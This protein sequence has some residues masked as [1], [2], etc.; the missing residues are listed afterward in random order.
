MSYEIESFKKYE[1]FFGSWYIKKKLG[2]GNFGAVFEI[3]REDFGTKYHAALKV[4]SIP[5]N[6]AE[7]ESIMND[8]LDEA[9]TEQYIKQ[10]V[11]KIIKEFELMAKLKGNSNIVSYEDHKVIKHEDD[12][13]WDILIRMELLTPMLK[14]VKT[15]V[16]T[17]RDVIGVGVDICRALELCEK[18]NIIHRDIKPENIFVSESGDFKLGDFG[19]A[20]Q[21]EESQTELTKIGT[22]T[23]MAPEVVKGHE[24][25]TS[26]DMYSLGVVLY[27]FLNHNRAPFMP[28]YPNPVD[29]SCKDMAFGERINGKKPFPTPTNAGSKELS[30]VIIK[31]C[32]YDPK[33]RFSSPSQM[34]RALENVLASES[35]EVLGVPAMSYGNAAEMPSCETPSVKEKTPSPV[36][37]PKIGESIE[38]E[39]E[40]K[41][42]I[43][44]SQNK[45][46]VKSGETIIL[47][48][49]TGGIV[50]LT[51]ASDSPLFVE[52]TKKD[53]SK[54]TDAS[55]S[56]SE[57]KL[58]PG[59]KLLVKN[60]SDKSVAF[61]GKF[62]AASA[63]EKE[64]QKKNG[65]KAKKKSKALPVI[66]VILVLILAA[67]AAVVLFGDKLGLFGEKQKAS[68]EKHEISQPADEIDDNS[69]FVESDNK[70]EK[71]KTS[72]EEEKAKTKFEIEGVPEDVLIDMDETVEISPEIIPS[73]EKHGDFVFESKDETVAKIDEIGRITP[74]SVGKTVVVI[75]CEN[76]KKEIN[77]NVVDSFDKIDEI[78][79]AIN[80]ASTEIANIESVTDKDISVFAE[81][82]SGMKAFVEDTGAIDLESL[83]YDDLVRI[84]DS[85]RVFNDDIEALKQE[86]SS[87][88]E[89]EKCPYCASTAHTKHPVCSYCGSL[90][91]TT[92]PKCPHCGS[93]DHT[94]HPRC[95]YCG[96]Y[97]HTSHP[98]CSYCGSLDHTTHP[99]CNVCGSLDHAE[100]PA[101]LPD[102]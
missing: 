35:D 18:H 39:P 40:E 30:D 73:D 5:K 75:K 17:R 6:K 92:H 98:K 52:I 70:E 25:D 64:P 79:S 24:Y 10:V 15:K 62:G 51:R 13:G 85:L 26:V 12:A 42:E 4:I 2:E 99:K 54:T 83:E 50:T 93:L 69:A 34:R 21:V 58:L 102:L 74:V 77:V 61:Y 1:P 14:Y 100:H 19:I 63:V 28:Q 23:Y 65:G 68:G 60:T 97:N 36:P 46:I 71:E 3:E 9:A 95:S 80:V 57:I 82:L 31:A 11:E 67:A 53:E 91:H 41:T 87:L 48:N 89:I 22:P 27:R 72:G 49:V 55:W 47:D 101:I 88:P 43:L 96:S 38:N 37:V 56:E 66:I 84:C 44:E 76:A 94:S 81:T 59:E 32:S 7:L 16:L 86:L 8:T 33:D 90:D 78:N 29:F 45:Y 20:K